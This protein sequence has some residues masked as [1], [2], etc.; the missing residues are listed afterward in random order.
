MLRSFLYQH[1][2]SL[3]RGSYGRV[4]YKTQLIHQNAIDSPAL[5]SMR[6]VKISPF[7]HHLA[8]KIVVLSGLDLNA[9]KTHK[10]YPIILN[11]GKVAV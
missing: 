3:K 5:F 9:V 7:D 2:H 10:N 1:V 8:H 4:E 6:N 11:W